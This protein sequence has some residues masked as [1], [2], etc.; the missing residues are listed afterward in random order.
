M[1]YP[2]GVDGC[3]I[4][5]AGWRAYLADL[6]VGRVIRL[7]KTPLPGLAIAGQHTLTSLGDKLLQLC[8]VENPASRHPAS[9]S[10]YVAASR[11]SLAMYCSVISFIWSSIH[12]A[13]FPF[14][15]NDV[16]SGGAAWVT[17]ARSA[18]VSSDLYAAIS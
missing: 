8:L 9:E 10:R 1:C 3:S 11:S 5:K 15:S 7:P 16:W 6:L 4:P 18:S 2:S 13:I 17:P 12:C 14:S